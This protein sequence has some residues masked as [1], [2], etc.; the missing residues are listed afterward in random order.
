MTVIAGEV[1]LTEKRV[2]GF[3]E[4]RTSLVVYNNHA[5]ATLYWSDVKGVS[6]DN[7][8][9]ILAGGSISLKIPEDDPTLEAWLISDTASTNYRIYAGYGKK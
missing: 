6:V 3:S 4:G 8:F 9:P 7:G 1:G 2:L 5:T